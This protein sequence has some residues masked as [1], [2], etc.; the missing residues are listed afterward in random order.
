MDRNT[1]ITHITRVTFIA[2]WV[3]FAHVAAYAEDALELGE[4]GTRLEL[5]ADDF[6]IEKMTGDVLRKVVQ[7]EPREVVLTTDKPYYFR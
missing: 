1:H 6:L 2:L 5:F 4:T 3:L 7:P